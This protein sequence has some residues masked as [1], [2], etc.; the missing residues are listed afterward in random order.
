[1]SGA[2][3]ATDVRVSFSRR[4]ES[5]IA[6]NGVSLSVPESGAVGLVGESGCGK[7]TLARVIT[8]IQ[9]PDA[10]EVRLDGEL[11][12]A[13]RTRS[14]HR[15]IQLIFQDPYSSLNPRRSIRSM[16]SEL[17]RVHGLRTGAGVE[18]RCAELMELVGLPRG[19][20]DRRPSAFSG[21][22]RQRLAIARALAVEPK[23]IVADQPVSALDVSIQAT[24]LELFARLRTELGVS[25]LLISHNLAVVRQLCDQVAVMY[26]G[27][28]VEFGER[29]QIFSAPEHEYTRTLLAAVPRLNAP[30]PSAAKSG[31]E[32]PT[33]AETG[34]GLRSSDTMGA[35]A[36]TAATVDA[37]AVKTN[38]TDTD[39]EVQ[40]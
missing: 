1:V 23:L 17:L 40:Q 20:L 3:Q 12:P 32:L 5:V 39:T 2:L 24:I 9:R 37:P 29:H 36:P 16:L 33:A 28:I 6:V 25:L 8:G 4:G 10:G 35:P 26:M 21:G 11:L 19:A 38:P 18:S 15:E 22:Q 27:E 7:S 31:G 30:I 34:D 13:R 14:Q